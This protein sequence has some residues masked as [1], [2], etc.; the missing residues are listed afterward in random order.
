M[1]SGHISLIPKLLVLS[2]SL[3]CFSSNDHIFAKNRDIW[4]D[5]PEYLKFGLS[6]KPGLCWAP[7]VCCT[8]FSALVFNSWRL[9]WPASLA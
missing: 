5:R 6:W 7:A 4:S 2:Q 1:L 9:Y 3:S 8:L